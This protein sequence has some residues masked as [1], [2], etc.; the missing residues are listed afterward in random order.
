MKNQKS[1]AHAEYRK[2]IKGWKALVLENELLTVT[3]LPEYGG[4]TKS[5]FFKPR[6]VEVL[7]QNP[8]GL[9]AKEDPLVIPNPLLAYHARSLGAWPEIFPHGSG[10]VAAGGVTLPMHGEVFNRAWDCEVVKAGGKEAAAKLTVEC[11]LMPLRL[12]RT[13][14][15]AKGSSVLV[16]EETATNLCDQPVDFMW[17]HHPIF[18]RPILSGESRIYAP[19]GKSLLTDFRAAGWPVHE[20][21]DLSLC[22]SEGAD[23]GEMFYLDSLS[24]GWCALVNPREKLGVAL[25]WDL[26][27]FRYVWI[28]REA[29]RS[30]GYPVAIEPFSNLPQARERGEKLLRLE[31]SQSMSTRLSLSVFMGLTKVTGVKPDGTVEG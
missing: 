9:P 4:W 14:R 19:T 3:V 24:D 23:T 16:V 30:K 12:E 2:R 8:R 22:P 13:M 25:N 11:H 27:L 28:W 5:I 18:S 6:K 29:N 17:G 26:S 15:L 1:S 10:P 21:K 31:G 7:W 20:G